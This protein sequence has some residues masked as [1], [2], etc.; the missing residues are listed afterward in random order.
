M[1]EIIELWEKPALGKYMIAGWHQ[2]A[3]AGEVSSGL[4]SYLVKSTRANQIGRIKPNGFYLFQIPGTHHLLRPTIKLE[5]GHREWLQQKENKIFHSDNDEH[6]FFLFLGEEPCQN[7]ELY[8]ETFFDIVE[9]LGITKIAIVAGVYGAMPYDKDRNIS[10]VYSLPGMKEQLSRYA[11]KFS[12]YEGGATISMYLADRAEHRGIQ[13][14]RFCAFVPSFDFS[15]L[16]A[17]VPAMAI[18]RDFKAWYDIMV[19]LNHIFD[20]DLDLT[21]LE[22][23]SNDLVSAWDTRIDQMIRTMPQLE[24]AEYIEKMN[25]GFTEISFEPLSDI[26]KEALGNLFDDI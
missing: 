1:S 16:S 26:W 5:K 9:E 25:D 17:L 23:R 15:Q 24:I 11:V 10:C 3:D 8:A 18:E 2:W 13:L 7:Q 12:N 14:F 21:D 6:G 22:K 4:L 19:R 20:L